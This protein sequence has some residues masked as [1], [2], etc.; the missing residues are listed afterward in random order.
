MK[1]PQTPVKCR[2]GSVY[3]HET[4]FREYRSGLSSSGVGGEISPLTNLPQRIRICICGEPKPDPSVRSASQDARSFSQS[5]AAA[6]AHRARQQPEAL[7]QE[8]LADLAPKKE[9]AEAKERLANI[10][11][12]LK[13]ILAEA[14]KSKE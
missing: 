6:K 2:C 11:L 7:L 14:I 13:V 1:K 5:V 8:L 4:E 3:F 12:A 10:E 9:L